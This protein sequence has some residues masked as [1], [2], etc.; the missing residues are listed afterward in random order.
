M[1]RKNTRS[2]SKTLL[3]SVL[4]SAPGPLVVGLG[5]LAGRSSTQIADF[6]RRSAE[7][8][9]IIMSFLIYKI[10]TKDGACN[11]SR[12]VLLERCSNAF[13]GA[14][15]CLG[16]GFMI[17]LALMSDTT[18]KGNVIPG[19]AIAIMG[20]IANT[21]FWRKYTLLHKKESNAI[22]A[23]QARLYRAKS[24]VDGCV[25]I[26]LLSVAIAPASPVS[27]WLDFIGSIIVAVYLIWCG[28]RT[29]WESARQTGT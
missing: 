8:L 29:V 27:A 28:I 25:T 16:G 14:M 20:V 2:G 24:L 1:S 18:D 19:L 17:A 7:L 12:K 21:L 26:A 22:L 23:V 3:M 15:M 10:T 9:A 11:K 6:V 13:V 4:M 5:L